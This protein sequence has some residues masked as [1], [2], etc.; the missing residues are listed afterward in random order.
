MNYSLEKIPPL[1]SGCC[2]GTLWKRWLL[3]LAGSGHLLEA[4]LEGYFKCYSSVGKSF[5]GRGDKALK[6]KLLWRCYSSSGVE[7]VGG[8]RAF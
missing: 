5:S 8:G 2:C 4:S 3:D 6:Q 7:G 1:A